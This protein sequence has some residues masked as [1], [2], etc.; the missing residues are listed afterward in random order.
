MPELPSVEIFKQYFDS[1]SLNQVIRSVKV[2]NPEILINL[3]AEELKNRLINQK[4]KGSKRYGKYLFGRLKNNYFL[5]L[6][7]GMTGY[8]KYDKGYR[9]PYT[10][11]LLEFKNG[12]N[13]SFIDMRKFGKIGLIR[14]VEQFIREK[15]LGPD[16]LEIDP[17]TFIDKFKKR[18]GLIKP[19]LMNQN[20]I[21]GI[22]NL[23]ADEILYQSCIHPLSKANKL[24]KNKLKQLYQEM[25]RVL[26]KAIEYQ[27]KPF[28]LPSSFLLPHRHLEGK[29]PQGG[30]LE[31]I[32]VG[33]RT[34]YY[35]AKQQKLYQ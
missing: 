12:N 4:F 27:D 35:C 23:Y 28:S 26:N 6:H 13:L 11:L 5:I 2:R 34:T 8:L 9:N 29:C 16:A 14:D 15:K 10:R 18:K 30:T 19:L 31:V 20:F 3:T 24:S 32:K 22:G 1:T 17:E 25:I 33:G 21:A 7:F